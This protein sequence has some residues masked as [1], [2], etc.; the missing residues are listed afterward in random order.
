MLLPMTY[1]TMESKNL[2]IFKEPDALDIAKINPPV[3]GRGE[4]RCWVARVVALSRR[5]RW[6]R[7]STCDTSLHKN[8][9]PHPNEQDAADHARLAT[10][11]R[12]KPA[13]DIYARKT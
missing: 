4:Q 8:F 5:S 11:C 12:T 3:Y 2:R 6:D 7:A 9:H 1:S 13:A 10:E